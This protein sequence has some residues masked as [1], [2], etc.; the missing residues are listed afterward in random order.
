MKLDF[1]NMKAEQDYRT[2]NLRRLS[3]TSYVRATEL[4]MATRWVWYYR[5]KGNVWREYED[6]NQVRLLRAKDEF[7]KDV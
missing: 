5:D 4:T 6:E 3:T 1:E 7:E 2:T